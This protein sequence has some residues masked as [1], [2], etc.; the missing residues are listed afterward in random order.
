MLNTAILLAISIAWASEYLFI[1]KADTALPPITVSAATTAI[2]AVVLIVVVRGFLGRQLLPFIREHRQVPLIMAVTAIALPKLSVVIAEDRITSDL[3][4]LVGTTVPILTLA[5]GIFVTRQ[6]RLSPYHVIGTLIALS[7]LLVFVDIGN[8]VTAETELAGAL[9]MM[10]GGVSFAINGVYGGLK[11]RT[12]DPYVLTTWVLIF[13]AI[14]LSVAAFLLE[15]DQVTMPNTEVMISLAGSGALSTGLAYIGY[16]ALLARSGA[17]FAS[18]YAYLVPPFG[19]VSAVLVLG[20]PLTA[21]HVIGVLLTLVGLW[22]L[23]GPERRARRT[24][25]ATSQ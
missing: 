6:T 22:A 5:I 3:A 11:A 7:G 9:I 17:A 23:T 24:E 14:G 16:Y 12:L 1:G 4:S 18:L 13:G 10:L 25:P 19:V 21:Q 8:L 2:A 15:R 20:H